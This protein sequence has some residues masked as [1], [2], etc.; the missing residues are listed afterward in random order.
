[1]NRRVVVTG[2]GPLTPIGSGKESFWD[3]LIAG[4]SGVQR[5]DD[6][7]DLDGIDVK[8]G[9]LVTDFNCLDY[10]DKKRA[11]RIERAT[12]MAIA[13]ARLAI[14][15][16]KLDLKS[17][18]PYRISVL[19]GTGIGEL[20][21][22]IDNLH[23]LNT[24]GPRRVS[25]FFIPQFMPNAIP[26]EIAIEF[27]CKGP[28]FGIVSA[29]ASSAHALG[30]AASIIHSNYSDLVIVG[31]SETLLLRLVYA[32][33]ARMGAL[34]QR[35]DEPAKASRPFDLQRDGFVLGEGAGCIILEEFAQARERGAKIYAELCG[36]GMSADAAHITAPA[37]GGEGAAAAMKMALSTAGLVPTDID[38]INAHGTSTLLND[39][40]ETAAIK[41]VFGGHGYRLKIS[42]TK[43]QIGHLLGAAG[44]VEAIATIL[45]IEHSYIPA[46]INYEYPDPDCDLDYTPVGSDCRVEVALTNSFGFG[47]QN[48][49]LLFSS[50]RVRSL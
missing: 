3:G 21:A 9:A 42:S 29:C 22:A 47:G 6:A 41:T 45:T 5:V 46:T 28:N 32:G 19:S 49:T 16:A 35:N 48:A 33:F 1:M 7:V 10:M 34:S 39:K 37:E 14:N 18:D 31:G 2:L 36:F 8:I 50:S 13:A 30:I 26:A 20:K 27:G 12:Q 17:I 15:D 38:Y 44:V 23:L 43:S 11:R 40:A 24:D 4:K 25:P